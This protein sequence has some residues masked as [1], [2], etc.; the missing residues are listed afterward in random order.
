MKWDIGTAASDSGLEDAHVPRPLR[1]RRREA[2]AS[3]PARGSHP[4]PR[5][6]ARSDVPT[7]LAER[8][9]SAARRQAAP[10]ARDKPSVEAEPG[11]LASR[12]EG[13]ASPGSGGTGVAG[14]RRGEDAALC[15][16]GRNRQRGGWNAFRCLSGCHGWSRE[17]TAGS[18]SAAPTLRV[19]PS[20]WCESHLGQRC[21]ERERQGRLP[22]PVRW[23]RT[24]PPPL[25]P[26]K[27]SALCAVDL[28]AGGF[29]SRQP[30][31]P[32]REPALPTE[33]PQPREK[34][35]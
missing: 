27:H 7:P 14:P 11:S 34:G 26:G 1:P 33:Q 19:M 4:S 2:E 31:L 18:R 16:P 23:R 9:A 8:H 13:S 25:G 32:G 30:C 10:P 17:G 35:R 24:P 20:P 22:D 3:P 21:P 12:R 29:R 5:V 28:W 6:P 15:H